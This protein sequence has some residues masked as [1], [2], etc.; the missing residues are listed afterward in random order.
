MT[1]DDPATRG[2]LA[3]LDDGAD[4][5]R[6]FES[7]DG[8]ASLSPRQREVARLIATGLANPEI[9]SEL[10]LD[11]ASVAVEVERLLGALGMRSRLEVAAWARSRT[12]ITTARDRAV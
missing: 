12:A 1:R 6:A 2:D 8:S 9:G 5:L 10:R 11:R 7:G 3:T 4:G